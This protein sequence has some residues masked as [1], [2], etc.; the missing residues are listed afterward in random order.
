[1][2][3]SCV[4]RSLVEALFRQMTKFYSG[5]LKG[6]TVDVSESHDERQITRPSFLGE[7]SKPLSLPIDRN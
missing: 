7:K 5:D 1:M 4:S 6:E 3:L 2:A